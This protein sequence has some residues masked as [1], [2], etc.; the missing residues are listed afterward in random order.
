MS[1][2]DQ[3][4]GVGESFT[5]SGGGFFESLSSFG[6]DVFSEALAIKTAGVLN[7]MRDDAGL[8]KPVSENQKQVLV[9]PG[10]ENKTFG[11]V[12]SQLKNW[13]MIGGAIVLILIV[14]VVMFGG[15]K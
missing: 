7:D 15:R 10:G 11:V 12:D 1:T 2:L 9:G 3:R 8:A 13:L 14:L 4:R 6:A 5:D